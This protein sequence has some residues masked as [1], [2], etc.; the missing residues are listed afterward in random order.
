MKNYIE[1]PIYLSEEVYQQVSNIVEYKNMKDLVFTNINNHKTI[2]N[3]IV[4]CVCDYLRQIKSDESNDIPLNLIG[5]QPIKNR[6]KEHMQKLGLTQVE[7]ASKTGISKSNMSLIVNNTN[8]PA[9]DYFIRIWIALEC[10]PIHQL[11]YRVE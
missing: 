5:K 4:G 11:V 6:I 7:L 3:F 10:P 8:Q 1:I 2:E 9:L